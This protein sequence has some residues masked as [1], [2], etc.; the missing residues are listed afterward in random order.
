[1]GIL[2]ME[3][4]GI[5]S[6][7]ALVAGLALGAAIGKSARVQKDEFLACL[8]ST[9]ESMQASQQPDFRVG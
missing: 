2:A 1:M 9:L 8:F 6:L 5:W 4:L 7:V 3:I